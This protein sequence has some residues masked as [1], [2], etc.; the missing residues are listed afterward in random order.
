MSLFGI[1]S[2]MF[3][4]SLF[5]FRNVDFQTATS[6]MDAVKSVLI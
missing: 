3:I 4:A 1:I 2:I 5:A 6:M